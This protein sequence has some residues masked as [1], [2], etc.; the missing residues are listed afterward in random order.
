MS[1]VATEATEKRQGQT[2]G[3]RQQRHPIKAERGPQTGRHGQTQGEGQSQRE[4][5]S[6]GSWHDDAP[7]SW[8]T[9]GHRWTLRRR[10]ARGWRL[11]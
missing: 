10:L 7:G 1:P 3:Q 6:A 9:T 8:Q 11:T 2:Q 5:E 4:R